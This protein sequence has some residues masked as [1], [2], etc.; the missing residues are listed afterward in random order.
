VDEAGLPGFYVSVWHGVWAPKG[1]PS[2][3]VAKLNAA[4]M[5]TLA[6]PNVRQRLGELGQEV[7]SA[8]RANAGS[9]AGLPAIR[10][11]QMWLIISPA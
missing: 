7:S 3:V 9:T 6:D 5:D 4:L 1:T 11:Q 10:G 2:A 8:Q